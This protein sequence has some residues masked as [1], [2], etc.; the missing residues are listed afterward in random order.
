MAPIFADVV[1]EVIIESPD[2]KTE[3]GREHIITEVSRLP[4]EFLLAT[5]SRKVEVGEAK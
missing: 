1:E 2:P 3:K 5:L 4:E